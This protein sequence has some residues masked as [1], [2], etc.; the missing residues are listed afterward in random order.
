MDT[1][2][3]A[4][5]GITRMKSVARGM[6]WWPNMDLDLEEK[7]KT[8]EICQQ[9]RPVP[10]ES[11]LHPWEWPE[12]PWS[13]LHL[14]YAGPFLGKLF[15]V[16]IDAHSKWLEVVPLNSSTSTVTIECLRRMF[17][18]HGLPETVVTDNGT[19]FTSDEFTVFMKKNGIHH[20]CVA[21]YHPASDG[22]AERAV[23]TF[24]NGMKRMTEGNIE[25]RISRFFV[26]VQNNPTNY[27]RS[28]T[29]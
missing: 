5:P 29:S 2:H 1:L 6:V 28:L 27:D 7:V 13:R 17:A 25:T 20:L 10:P 4:H 23:Q 24:K 15:L 12:K 21:P 22:L 11:T 16:C 14:D 26:Q 8:C 3:E 19:C 18:T 9:S